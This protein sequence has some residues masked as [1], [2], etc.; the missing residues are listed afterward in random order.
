MS[1]VPVTSSIAAPT[2][3]QA[4]YADLLAWHRSQITDSP[5][6]Y[7]KGIDAIGRLFRETNIPTLVP[8][9]PFIL[10]LKGAPFR[11]DEHFPLEPLYRRTELPLKS[12]MKCGRQV[13]KSTTL[14][15]QGII[16][17]ATTPYLN[18]LYVAPLFEQIR[19]FSNNYVRPF[20]EDSPIRKQLIGEG[21][22]AKDNSVFQ[23][24]FANGSNMFFTFAFLDAE[25]ARGI[26]ADILNID[27]VQDID[28]DF[29]PVLASCL[30]ASKFKMI[31]YSGTPKTTDNTI[32]NEWEQSS[33]A[34]WMMKCQEPCG[35]YNIASLETGLDKMVTEKGFCCEKC[36]RLLNPRAGQYKHSYK[37]RMFRFP[38]WHVPQPIMPMHCENPRAWFSLYEKK[39]R[40]PAYRYHNEVLGESCDVGSR[41]V[42]RTELMAAA[43]LPWANTPEAAHP[44]LRE[45]SSVMMGVDWGGGGGGTIKKRRGQVIVSGGTTSFTVVS[46]VG[47]RPGSPA[48]HL[49]FAVRLPITMS[50]Q[51]EITYILSLFRRFSCKILAHDYGGAGSLRETLMLQAGLRPDK[52]MPCIYVR[53]VAKPIV[54]AEPPTDK[55]TRYYYS[56]DKTRSLALLCAVIK[57]GMGHMPKWSDINDA[58]P[59]IYEDFLAL[60]ESNIENVY[61]TDR[62]LITRDP[63]K[64]DDFCHSFNFACAAEWH[65]NQHYP[66]LAKQFSISYVR[67]T[68]SEDTDTQF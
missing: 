62:Y 57:A 49:L 2:A 12:I 19:R 20:I 24:T 47:F 14:A 50:P 28:F 6:A 58:E 13:S 21:F 30:D 31:Q 41:L 67:P 5:A 34:H 63:K 22:R 11:L 66:N 36:G 15:A 10:R 52:V 51:E 8:I 4:A 35:H 40:W 56:V 42:T 61:G 68:S 26:A 25:R 54:S 16:R 45:Y 46:V 38:G 39:M 37:D 27:E 7:S 32:H 17:S 23:R 3:A 43:D 65:H 55:S 29:L 9:L 33:Q 60:I 18:T 48:P 64:P 59:C 44:H 53:S 1:Y